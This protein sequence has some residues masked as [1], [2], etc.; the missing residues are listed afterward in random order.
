MSDYDDKTNRLG[1]QIAELEDRL[2]EVAGEVADLNSVMLPFFAEFQRD[3]LRYHK[4]LLT[5]QREIADIHALKGILDARG[6]G[7]V[8][9]PL[10]RFSEDYAS[11][12]DQYNR[13]YKGDI[14]EQIDFTA[15]LPP[16]SERIKKYYKQVVIKHHPGLKEDKTEKKKARKTMERANTA[17]VNRDEIT[18]ASMA[19]ISTERSHLPAVVDQDVKKHLRDRSYMLDEVIGKLEAQQFEFRYGELPKIKMYAEHAQKQGRDLLKELSV[20]IQDK[21]R[22]EHEELKRLKISMR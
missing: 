3:V 6:I 2:A 22:Q 17:Y 9:S 14:P 21:L 13:I 18:L 20:E 11:V 4:A 8:D 5:V 16:A 15:H 1:R 10:K 19:S 7:E 12:Q